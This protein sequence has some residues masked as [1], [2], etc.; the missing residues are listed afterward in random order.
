MLVFTNGCFDILH[1]GHVEY[2]K[3]SRRLGDRLVVGLNS[4][5]SVARLKPGR[6][7]NNQADRKAV[8]ESLWCVDAVAIFEE[9]TPYELIKLLKPNI[10]T[11]AADYQSNQVVGSD[12]AHV[13]IIPYLEGYSTTKLVNA[14]SG[15]G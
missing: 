11:K 12:L 1:R 6:P 4:D 13:V 10:I 8:L 15:R 14:I 9:D 5:A 2:L 7:I 3:A